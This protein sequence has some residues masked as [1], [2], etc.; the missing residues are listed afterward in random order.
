MNI[1]SDKAIIAPGVKLGENVSI[2]AYTVIDSDVEISDNVN[3]DT[4]VRISSGA[5]IHSGVKIFHSAVIAGEPQDLKFDGKPTTLEIGENTVVREFATL[6]RGTQESGTTK[7]GKNCYL[8]AY[9]HIP[10]DSVVGDSVIISNAV[11]MGGHVHIDD[12]VTIAGLVGIHQFVR[13]GE[14]SFIAF[15]ARVTQDIPPYILA[16][17]T[18]LNYKGLN[19]VG[20][21]RRGFT[22]DQLKY[23]KQTYNYIFGSKYNISDAVKAVKDSVQMTDEVKKILTFIETSERGII[24]K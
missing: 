17:G 6:S 1:I 11:N 21:K 4:S 9:V 24:R 2:G 7:V 12:W 13:I 15:S 18:P 23:I 16:G 8:M 22:E 20:L 10:H 14:H 5:R 19:L 3:I